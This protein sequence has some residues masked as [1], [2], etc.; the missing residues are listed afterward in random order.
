MR[1]LKEDV[2]EYYQYYL[3]K[4]GGTEEY[5]I[6]WHLHKLEGAVRDLNEYI[7]SNHQNTVK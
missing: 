4:L 7:E 6:E 1:E 3:K 2:W 5:G